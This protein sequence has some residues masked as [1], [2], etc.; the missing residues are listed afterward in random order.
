MW[1]RSRGCGR[2]GG[3]WWVVDVRGKACV[4]GGEGFGKILF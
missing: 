1:E 4:F 3:G 2:C